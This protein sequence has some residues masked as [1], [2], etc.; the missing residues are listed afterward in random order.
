MELSQDQL[1]FPI[2]YFNTLAL[3]RTKI[4][5]RYLFYHCC[6]FLRSIPL[7][8]FSCWRSNS[9]PFV[10]WRGCWKTSTVTP[11]I[12]KCHLLFQNKM[13]RFVQHFSVT[14]FTSFILCVGWSGPLMSHLGNGRRSLAF[15]RRWLTTLQTYYFEDCFGSTILSIYPRYVKR[16]YTTIKMRADMSGVLKT[17]QYMT[18]IFINNT[19]ITS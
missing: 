18:D 13:K 1:L 2:M 6:R 14:H 10:F 8:M 9:G 3:I 12:E 19:L 7:Y 5:K 4:S 15:R 17:W 11:P 16:S